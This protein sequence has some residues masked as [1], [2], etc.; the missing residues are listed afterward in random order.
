MRNSK[1]F[2]AFV[3]SIAT[4]ENK[5]LIESIKKGYS[6]L[7]EA[8]DYVDVGSSPYGEDCAQVGSENYAE[9]SRKELKAYARQLIRQFGQPPQGASLIIKAFP[10]D[11]GTYHEL[12]VKYNEDNEEAAHYAF[13]LEGDGPEFWDDEAKKELGITP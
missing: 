7:C 10:H 2:V 5:A 11:F 13:K 12:V 9:Q 3:E 4:N 6:S 1:K 8:M